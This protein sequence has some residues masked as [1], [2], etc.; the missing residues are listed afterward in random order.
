MKTS[1]LNYSMLAYILT[2]R[3]FL[4]SVEESL[5]QPIFSNWQTKL[6]TCISIASHPGIFQTSQISSTT[7][8]KKIDFLTTNHKR[9]Y[10]L[11]IDLIPNDW[12]HL[13]KTETSQMKNPF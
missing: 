12:K 4:T 6:I 11:I 5:D 3:T 8:D 1:L 9:I 10:K 13:L 2:I 7:I